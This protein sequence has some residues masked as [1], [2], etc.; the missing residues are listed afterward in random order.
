MLVWGGRS[1]GG[2]VRGGRSVEYAGVRWRS[3]G[4]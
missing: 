3:V 4:V 2:E 1:V